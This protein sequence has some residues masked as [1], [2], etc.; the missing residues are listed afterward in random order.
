MTIE[1]GLPHANAARAGAHDIVSIDVEKTQFGAWEI[2]K[3]FNCPDTYDSE[4]FAL[5]QRLEAELWT[6][7][8]RFVN[9]MGPQRPEWVKRLS[10][11]NQ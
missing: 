2:A 8:D 5:A 10:D 4:F 7:D 1:P 6:A 3:R 11:F 9:S